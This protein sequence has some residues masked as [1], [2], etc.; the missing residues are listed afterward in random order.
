MY[1]GKKKITIKDIA[2]VLKIHHSTVSRALRDYPDVNPQT[3]DRVKV[4][5]EEFNY[6]PNLFARNLKTNNTQVIGVIVPEIKNF[7]LQM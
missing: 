4:M 3:K 5:A 1:S 7:F 2:V 6:Q